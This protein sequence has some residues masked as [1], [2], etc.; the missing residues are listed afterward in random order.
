MFTCACNS[1]SCRP[2]RHN[3]NGLARFMGRLGRGREGMER[4]ISRYSL[5]STCCYY[6]TALAHVNKFIKFFCI[7]FIAHRIALSIKQLRILARPKDKKIE[8]E[9]RQRI[10]AGRDAGDAGEYI[11]PRSASRRPAIS[12]H[13]PP[14]RQR[15]HHR[16]STRTMRI[17]KSAREGDSRKPQSLRSHLRGLAGCR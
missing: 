8:L 5:L 3:Q 10:G 17:P 6:I 4:T 9:D 13:Y 1:A 14:A 7:F 12:R 2:Y 15:A 11:A 16:A